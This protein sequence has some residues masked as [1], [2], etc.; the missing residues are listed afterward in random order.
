M[1]NEQQQLA[2]ELFLD[3]NLSKTEIAEKVGVDRRTIRIWSQEGNWENLRRSSQHLPAMVA[4][5]CY[6]LIDQYATHLLSDGGTI[7][8]FSHKDAH[9]IN[10]LASA[11][12]K[13]KTRSAVNESMEMFNYFIEDVKRKDPKMAENI[14]PFI[15][16]YLT[17]RKDITTSDFRLSGFNE[18]CRIPWSEEEKVIM[19]QWADEKDNE[20]ILDEMA[21]ARA[22]AEKKEEPQLTEEEKATMERIEGYKK[23]AAEAAAHPHRP[24]TTTVGN[25]AGKQTTPPSGPIT[26]HAK[27]TT[28]F[29][30]PPLSPTATQIEPNPPMSPDPLPS[31]APVNHSIPVNIWQTPPHLNTE[32]T[33]DLVEA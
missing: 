27:P 13:I 7:S 18:D 30:P 23:V 32:D 20:L 11:I 21:A 25:P 4:E 1:K 16:D 22:A 26:N 33:N 3:T 31:P 17:K 14:S 5:K 29:T 6:Y 9:A 24:Q 12:K 2:K 28:S 8:T 15:E 19:E 10:Q